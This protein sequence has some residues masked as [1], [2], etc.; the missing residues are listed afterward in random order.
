[1]LLQ[2][3]LYAT[4]MSCVQGNLKDNQP[5]FDLD[6]CV[7]GVVTVSRGYPGSYKK[8]LVITGEL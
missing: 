7:V 6:S 5:V 1:M 8:G 3:D 4:C 2:S